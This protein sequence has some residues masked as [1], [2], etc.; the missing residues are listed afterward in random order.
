[1]SKTHTDLNYM[2]TMKKVIIGIGEVLFLSM[3]STII[4]HQNGIST[5]GGK[6]IRL[7]GYLLLGVLIFSE[8]FLNLIFFLEGKNR[9]FNL[10]MMCI[11]FVFGGLYIVLWFLNYFG[12]I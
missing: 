8:G 6:D 9:W 7:F 5:I 4:L 2:D 12:K 11:V 1:M 10:M 3:I